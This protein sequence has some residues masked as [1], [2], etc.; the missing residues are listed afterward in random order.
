MIKARKKWLSVLLTVAMLAALLVPLATPAQAA[1]TYTVSN[2]PL[3]EAGKTYTTD[4]PTITIDLKALTTTGYVY[5]SLPTTP[6]GWAIG[7]NRNVPANVGSVPNALASSDV[8]VVAGDP[9]HPDEIFI[10]IKNVTNPGNDGRI[11]LTLTSLTIPSGFSGD[12]KLSAEAPDTSP[13]S[14]GD[15][16]IARVGAGDV[17]VAVD[18]VKT[19]TAGGTNEVY[20]NIR[21]NAPN[22]L[23]GLKLTL[24]PG[25]RWKS[26][27][28]DRLYWGDINLGANPYSYGPSL[29][30][31]RDLKI[32]PQT[33]S[34]KAS[35]FKVKAVIDIDE[36]VAKYGDVVVTVSG[37]NGTSVA[38]SSVTVAKYG[39]YGAKVYTEN[40][41]TI[42]AGKAEEHLDTYLV[43]E[44]SVPGSLVANRTIT[45]TLPENAR[46]SKDKP[47]RDDSRSK[48]RGSLDIQ[49]SFIGSDGRTLKG[50]ISGTSS[51]QSEGAKLVF[52]DFYV[53]T[54]PDF[55]GDLK[56]EV[57]GSAGL[58]GSVVLAK[59]NAPVKASA[60][61]TIPEVK[62]G[63]PGQAVADFTITE[64][65]KEA[66]VAN[67]VYCTA[68][69]YGVLTK[70][71]L[72]NRARITIK[73][74]AGV[75]FSGIPKVEVVSGDLVVDTAA[76]ATDTSP[77]NEG[78]LYIPIKSASTVPSTIKI[79]G[80]KVTL[81]RT[82]PEG[83]LVFKV[84]DTAV[85][86]TLDKDG[87][88]TFFPGHKDA[89]S[90]VVA[91]CV[92]PAPTQ[93]LGKAVFKIGEA[94]Y[95]IG[96]KE[97]TMDAAAYIE[98]D[99]AFAPM[100]YVAY[101]AGVTQDNIL[102]NPATRTA[103]FIKGDR[104]VQVTADSNILVV[105]GTQIAMDVKAVIKD[106]RFFLPVRWLSVAL[107]CQVD[108]DAQNQQ[109][110][111]TRTQ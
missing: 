88:D 40:V 36:T 29:N 85:N 80:V 94:K 33:T 65:G 27:Q 32:T 14:S 111:V 76:V 103:T 30:D 21:E 13:F 18:D 8:D 96:D 44:E 68:D 17:S 99:R 56:V 83:D 49:W 110:I 22:A 100:R 41:G 25:F 28:T 93:T 72:S 24:P 4:L 104:V 34:T 10:N 98:N 12:V 16:I 39:E 38:T 50:T 57:G 91:K 26:V 46:W 37:E 11:I 42:T 67:V 90:V 79:S 19:I 69:S 81:D 60:E 20:L 35:Y 102:W 78:L 55:V 92:T 66:V 62:I 59:V 2:V 87:K 1:A 31:G 86:Q 43:I 54:A 105:N 74:P 5:L 97:Y 77:N 6:S 64:T 101:A 52:K 7:A 82:V 108:W 84:R 53:T 106:G 61:G 63:L 3:L 107:G 45:L 70:V 73:A 71:T 48:N 47:T 95:T 23:K 51:G 89:A 58:S 75:T 9:Q 109:V 15:I